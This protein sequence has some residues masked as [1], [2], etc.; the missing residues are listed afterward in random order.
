[1]TCPDNCG[2]KTDNPCEAGWVEVFDWSVIRAD[3]NRH[4]DEAAL[5][6]ATLRCCWQYGERILIADLGAAISG[7]ANERLAAGAA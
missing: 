2:R 5:W 7:E 1:M 4:P 6:F 3:D